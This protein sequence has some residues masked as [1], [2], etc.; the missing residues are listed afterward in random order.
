MS[1]RPP[2]P[3]PTAEAA[4]SGATV[5]PVG[6]HSRNGDD[7]VKAAA[8]A[9][10]ETGTVAAAAAAGNVQ[11]NG[12]SG[13]SIDVSA[14]G[15]AR[16]E[17]S[18]ADVDGA[19]GGREGGAAGEENGEHGVASVDDD[20]EV[21]MPVSSNSS[22]SLWEDSASDQSGDEADRSRVASGAGNDEINDFVGHTATYRTYTGCAGNPLSKYT[23]VG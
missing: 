6:S 21:E 18:G 16:S 12:G 10:G 2:S 19:G 4:V 1:P 17:G 9:V 11:S 23:S 8:A 3:G 7:G 22:A 5:P 14:C 13:V 15:G 20:A